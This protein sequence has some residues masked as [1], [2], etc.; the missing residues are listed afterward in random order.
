MR[1]R[2]WIVSL[3]LLAVTSAAPFVFRASV[4]AQE[5]ERAARLKWEYRVV[6]EERLAEAGE[7]GWEVIAVTGGQPYVESSAVHPPA[8]AV[9][10]AP[11]ETTSNKVKF[12]PILYHMKR[13]K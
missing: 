7:Q 6:S 1:T 10:G 4:S 2:T 9:Q 12:A 11:K 13:P 3:L 8:L 5:K